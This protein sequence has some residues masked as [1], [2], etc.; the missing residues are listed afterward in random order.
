MMSLETCARLTL[1]A[2]AK[3]C[4]DL[5][6]PPGKIARWMNLLAPGFLDR[7]ILN[8]IEKDRAK[9]EVNFN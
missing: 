6:M 4:R 8:G 9:R 3:H 1:Q 7:M 2:V 5:V